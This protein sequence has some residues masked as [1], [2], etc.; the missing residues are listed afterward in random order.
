PA[1]SSNPPAQ[2]SSKPPSARRLKCAASTGKSTKPSCAPASPSPTESPDENPSQQP[3]GDGGASDE[4]N[5]GPS[6]HRRT[7]AADADPGP[8]APSPS[9]GPAAC[10]PG[11]TRSTLATVHTACRLRSGTARC[12][13][14][15][16]ACSPPSPRPPST[17]ASNRSN[18][19]H[20][21]SP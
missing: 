21:W 14:A 18:A 13:P 11:S 19:T 9:P 15:A 8:P 7:A 12:W 4:A 6:C 20:S 3:K 10:R 2:A 16:T 17:G 1:T 5:L